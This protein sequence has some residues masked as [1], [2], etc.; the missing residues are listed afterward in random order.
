MDYLNGYLFLGEV[1]L[2]LA[3]AIKNASDREL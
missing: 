2:E 3:K 1:K